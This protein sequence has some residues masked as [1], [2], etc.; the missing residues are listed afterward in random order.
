M[1]NLFELAVDGLFKSGCSREQFVNLPREIKDNIIHKIIEKLEIID[2]QQETIESLTKQIK[3]LNKNNTYLSSELDRL[4]AY[5]LS[6]ISQ[7]PHHPFR[8]LF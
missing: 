5:Y 6:N 7:R 8:D 4:R 2:K 3:D 1:E